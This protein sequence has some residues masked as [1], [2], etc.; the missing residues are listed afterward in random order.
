MPQ[1]RRIHGDSEALRVGEEQPHEEGMAEEEEAQAN[2]VRV[3][4]DQPRGKKKEAR[5]TRTDTFAQ[6][7]DR[8][9]IARLKAFHHRLSGRESIAIV[10]DDEAAILTDAADELLTAMQAG[11]PVPQPKVNTRFH[12]HAQVEGQ[13]LQRPATLW[14]AIDDL[15]ACH[16][17]Y[18]TQQT[19]I[20]IAKAKLR[21]VQRERGEQGVDQANELMQVMV[22]GQRTCDL[23]NQRR[24]QLLQ[25]IDELLIEQ[26]RRR[27]PASAEPDVDVND[28]PRNIELT[29]GYSAN[30]VDTFPMSPSE[31]QRRLPG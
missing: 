11:E 14:D 6:L 26:L 13:A 12:D 5:M 1:W 16:S 10:L 8:V 27:E 29:E 4:A 7:V 2:G 18:F 22:G 17:H 31:I 30:N 3:A 15:V 28:M 19:L 25:W 20:N 9:I 21:D 23:E 24:N